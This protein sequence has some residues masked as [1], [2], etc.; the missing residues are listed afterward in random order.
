WLNSEPRHEWLQDRLG[1][2]ED[3]R[4]RFILVGNPGDHDRSDSSHDPGDKKTL[5]SVLLHPLQSGRD[6]TYQLFHGMNCWVDGRVGR[7]RQSGKL[8][9]AL[10]DDENVAR[11]HFDVGRYVTP[12]NEILE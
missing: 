1:I 2:N 5:P 9:E 7:L 12:F 6:L 10:W 11:L 8:E 3:T 4:T